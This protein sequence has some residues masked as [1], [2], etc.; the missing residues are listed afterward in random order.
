MAAVNGEMS[1]LLNDSTSAPCRRSPM[2]EGCVMSCGAVMGSMGRY[3]SAW[4]CPLGP[5]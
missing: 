5:L 1:F 3:C 4:V 2:A